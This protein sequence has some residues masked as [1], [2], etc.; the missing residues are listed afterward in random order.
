MEDSA[1][2]HSYI[3]YNAMSYVFK[4]ELRAEQQWFSGSFYAE[5]YESLMMP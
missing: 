3:Q 4:C 2:E 1:V 5:K